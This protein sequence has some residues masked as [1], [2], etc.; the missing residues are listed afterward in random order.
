M[1]DVRFKT[2][3]CVI[4]RDV[5]CAQKM[6]THFEEKT[7]KCVMMRDVRCAKKMMTHLKNTEFCADEDEDGPRLPLFP[8][9]FSSS[10]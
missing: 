5:R 7:Q 6:M 1:R 4:M 9:A 2:Q 8:K 3:K 10:S